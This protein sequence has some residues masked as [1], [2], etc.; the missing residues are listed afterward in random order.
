MKLFSMSLFALGLLA[1]PALAQEAIPVVADT[2]GDGV[3][4]ADE[5]RVVWV[6]LSDDDI[7][8]IDTDADG[9]ITD[10]ELRIAWDTTDVLKDNVHGEAEDKQNEANTG[11]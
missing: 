1:A 10:E 7:K 2:N 6:D 5:L 11:G 9:S 8:I 3:Y 4:S